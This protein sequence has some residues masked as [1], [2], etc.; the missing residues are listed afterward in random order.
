MSTARLLVPGELAALLGLP[1]QR[2]FA[3][4]LPALRR[5]GFPE[6]VPAMG[7]RWDR[8]AVHRWLD[9]HAGFL[10][11]T[12]GIGAQEAELIRRAQGLAASSEGSSHASR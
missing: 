5:A 2:S 11:N 4:R 8:E 7:R 6:P 3:A 9:A 1:S 12:A 10:P